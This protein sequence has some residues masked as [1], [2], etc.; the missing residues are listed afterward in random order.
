MSRNDNVIHLSFSGPPSKA[1]GPKRNGGDGSGG[2][3]PMGDLDNRVRELEK[4]VPDIRERL[5]KI[6]AN[7]VSIQ[8]HSATKADISDTV[9]KV[10]QLETVISNRVSSLE[11]TLIKWFVATSIGTV[12]AATTITFIIARA[13][14]GG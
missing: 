9:A 3:P 8:Q 10:S 12:G 2:E 1:T 14:S 13:T 11:T 5:A 6:E 4:A 7:T